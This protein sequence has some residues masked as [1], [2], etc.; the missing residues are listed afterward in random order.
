MPINFA[1]LRARMVSRQLRARGIHDERLLAAMA[2]IPRELFVPACDR[3]EAYQDMPLPIGAGQTISQPYMTAL[4]LQLLELEGN[5]RALEIGAGSGYAAAVMGALTRV[6]IAIEL[7]PEL[8][9]QAR[10]NLL[11]AHAGANVHIIQGDGS[12]GYPD[13]APYDAIAVSA[14]A[15]SVPVELEEQ[16]ADGGR[17]V[18]PVGDR[19]EQTLEI[20]TRSGKAIVR[21]LAGGCRFV[22][23]RGGAGWH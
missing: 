10:L 20:L 9:V 8:A 21:R 11:A 2:A 22:P 14:G 18:I 17:M 13:E 5:E 19:S 15:P 1:E 16:L 7:V 3:P 12:L 4:M 23:L 6:V